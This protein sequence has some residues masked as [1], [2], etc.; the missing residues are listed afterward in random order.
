M[1]LGFKRFLIKNAPLQERQH[2]MLCIPVCLF[3]VAS[4]LCIIIVIMIFFP[5][6][7][8][9]TRI[10]T[11]RY[12]YVPRRHHRRRHCLSAAAT[13]PENFKPVAAAQHVE[14]DQ[15]GRA[16]LIP[17]EFPLTTVGSAVIPTVRVYSTFVP[18]INTEVSGIPYRYK[19]CSS[20]R[21]AHTLMAYGA[22]STTR[23]RNRFRRWYQSFLVAYTYTRLFND[24]NE[25]TTVFRPEIDKVTRIMFVH[26]LLS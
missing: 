6:G 19:R 21:R 12:T 18:T 10:L 4:Q 20:S 24:D 8:F 26:S 13:A 7:V 3:E 14:A 17:E 5:S 22:H 9:S 25:D 1:N 2:T 23:W 15:K 11:I 16:R